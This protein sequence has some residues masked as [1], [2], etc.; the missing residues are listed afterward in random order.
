M[1]ISNLLSEKKKKKKKRHF[2]ANTCI[3]FSV[4]AKLGSNNY[5]VDGSFKTFI[6]LLKEKII[7]FMLNGVSF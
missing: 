1:Y 6:I 5:L 7:Y 3:C 4:S 2:Y